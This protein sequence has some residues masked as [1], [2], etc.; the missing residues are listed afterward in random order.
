M[1]HGPFKV[2][3][4]DIHII[5]PRPVAA[6][7]RSRLRARAGRPLEDGAIRGSPDGKPWGRV[8]VDADRSHRRQGVTTR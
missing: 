2:L 6:L 3:D 8:A 1:A 7:Y 5:E 4:S